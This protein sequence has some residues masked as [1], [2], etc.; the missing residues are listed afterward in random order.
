MDFYQHF[1]GARGWAR[2]ILKPEHFWPAITVDSHCFHTFHFLCILS[3]KF[4]MSR[5][6]I[7]IHPLPLVIQ[8]RV[9]PHLIKSAQNEEPRDIAII[10]GNLDGECEGR[11][12]AKPP[13][14]RK[15]PSSRLPKSF[16]GWGWGRHWWCWQS[17]RS[18]RRRR[19][20]WGARA[21]PIGVVELSDQ[22]T[23]F[24]PITDLKEAG[25]RA[26]IDIGLGIDR[27]A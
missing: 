8:R 10:E 11:L 13:P 23:R 9:E 4:S 25:G 26:I 14:L 7:S 6:K 2:C 17:R 18:W 19:W 3:L 1:T 12:L 27:D 24:V 15:R 20:W 16:Y 22:Q 5:D 21:I